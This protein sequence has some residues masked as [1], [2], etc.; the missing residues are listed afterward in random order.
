MLPIKNTLAK[1]NR[2]FILGVIIF[3]LNG[4]GQN[5]KES[6]VEDDSLKLKLTPSYLCMLVKN[7]EIKLGESLDGV[8]Q[9]IPK[10]D[11]A[12]YLRSL[13]EVFSP[14]FK[15]HG[16]EKGNDTY[17]FIT[18]NDLVYLILR[19]HEQVNKTYIDPI[20]NQYKKAFLTP[21]KKITGTTGTYWFWE[22]NNQRLMI[23]QTKDINQKLGIT[24]A[25]GNIQLMDRLRMDPFSA[26][27]D[28]SIIFQKK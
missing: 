18:C 16:W 9:K 6:N 5:K 15:A 25:L 20:L 23:C 19:T 12:L 26:Q 28:L 27:K 17:A 7:E 4:C 22:N 1:I 13:P 2:F 21:H 11:K 3:I 24:V 10:P 8:Y 14:P